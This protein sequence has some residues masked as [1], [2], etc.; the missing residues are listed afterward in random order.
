[1]GMFHIGITH[2]FIHT[3]THMETFHLDHLRV[4]HMPQ[5]NINYKSN[6]FIFNTLT[7]RYNLIPIL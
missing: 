5:V 6:D 1:M 3:N 2:K 4:L 7:E